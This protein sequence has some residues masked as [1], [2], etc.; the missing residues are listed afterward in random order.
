[1]AAHATLSSLLSYLSGLLNS[2]KEEYTDMLLAPGVSVHRCLL[3]KLS[4][5]LT[6]LPTFKDSSKMITVVLPQ[7]E[8]ITVE[9]MVELEYTGRYF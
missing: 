7:V 3:G 2:I 8:V 6:S 5:L 4:P 1:M 9:K